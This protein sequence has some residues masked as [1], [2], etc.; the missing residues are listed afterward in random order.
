MNDTESVKDYE[1]LGYKVK[2]GAL[3]SNGAVE[4][5]QIVNHVREAA[6]KLLD[7]R[8]HL[9]K[10]EVAIL[11]ALSMAQDKL[12]LEAEF[13]DSVNH[14]HKVTKDTLQKIEDVPIM[15]TS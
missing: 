1:V 15:T 7:K 10:G 12:E 13:R 2:L 4:P 9:S 3:K 8:P 14:F 6:N 11:V 5:D